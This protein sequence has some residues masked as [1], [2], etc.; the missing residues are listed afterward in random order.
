MTNLKFYLYLLLDRMA[1]LELKEREFLE[2]CKASMQ[3]KI[4]AFGTH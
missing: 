4:T 3:G 1:S 2:L